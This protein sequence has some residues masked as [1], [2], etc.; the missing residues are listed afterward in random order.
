MSIRDRSA[1]L[2]RRTAHQVV[3]ALLILV[4][5]FNARV[6]NERRARSFYLMVT[7]GSHGPF[8]YVEH[9]VFG[10]P[11]VLGRYTNSINHVDGQ[12][13][14]FLQGIR[15]SYL[16]VLYGDHSAFVSTADYSSVTNGVGYVPG[17]V[18]LLD[19]GE[20]RRPQLAEELP[21]GG[22]DRSIA[23]LY[24]L[25]RNSAVDGCEGA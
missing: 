17:F 3:F 4:F 25:I 9:E 19:D 15:G 20:I 12:L 8:D 13:R 21:A 23:S 2:P 24:W 11:G 10:A 1:R 22:A 16:V 14:A 5:E 7:I 6:V 18:F